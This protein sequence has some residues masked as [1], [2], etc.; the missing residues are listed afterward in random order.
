ME[1]VVAEEFK[2]FCGEDI[3]PDDWLWCNRCHKCYKA[4]DFRKLKNN[5]RIFL[6]CHY[7]NCDGDLPLDSR[8]WSQ[9]IQNNPTLPK[10]PVKGVVYEIQRP[11]DI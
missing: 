5:G 7:K 4:Y 11:R 8:P 3:K 10:R 6:L 2:I 1:R 9:L